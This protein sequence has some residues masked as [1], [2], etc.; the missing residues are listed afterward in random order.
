MCLAVVALPHVISC[1]SPCRPLPQ[2]HHLANIS[3]CMGALRL[4]C[5]CCARC[6]L[7]YRCILL[8]EAYA[9]LMDE[10]QRA[11]YDQQ[12]DVALQ[13]QEDGYT[14]EPAFCA[15]EG[16]AL[17]GGGWPA[18]HTACPPASQRQSSPKTKSWVRQARQPIK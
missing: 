3:F 1:G 9:V 6:H 8:N 18:S 10:Q 5:A 12:L 7:P 2:L 16:F 14:G 17:L 13:D 15:P 11:A 4:T